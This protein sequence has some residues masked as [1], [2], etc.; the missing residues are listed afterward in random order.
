MRPIFG[1]TRSRD[2]AATALAAFAS[3]TALRIF[4]MPAVGAAGRG[5][6]RAPDG[7]AGAVGVFGELGIE[8]VS[9]HGTGPRFAGS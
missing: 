5:G 7:R 4:S 2:F 6:G 8:G 3:S 1:C 9:Q